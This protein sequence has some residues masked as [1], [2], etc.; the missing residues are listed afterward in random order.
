MSET[1][2]LTSSPVKQVYDLRPDPDNFYATIP[3]ATLAPPSRSHSTDKHWDLEDQD[4]T[5][6]ITPFRPNRRKG[7]DIQLGGI[8]FQLTDQNLVRHTKLSN[9]N[10]MLRNF[11]SP[12]SMLSLSFGA[13]FLECSSL[14]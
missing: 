11:T 14:G 2:L 7:S 6:H 5:A 12:I 3:E 4:T 13:S 1:Y 9:V 10:P 8:D